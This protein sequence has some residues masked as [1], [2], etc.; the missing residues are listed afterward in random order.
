M[1]IHWHIFDCIDK[2][3]E[4]NTVLKKGDAKLKENYRPVSCL[5]AASKLLEMLVCEQTTNFINVHVISYFLNYKSPALKRNKYL[6]TYLLTGQ[7]IQSSTKYTTFMFSSQGIVHLS[8]KACN[9][10]LGSGTFICN[11]TQIG[12]KI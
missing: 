9:Q 12:P 10:E 4:T 3:E 1:A 5:P 8:I 6:L 11:L 2:L 7:H